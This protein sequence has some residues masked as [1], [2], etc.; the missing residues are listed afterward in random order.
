MAAMRRWHLPLLM[1][2]TACSDPE[3]VDC[4]AGTYV[5][6]SCV[7][8][9]GATSE[10]PSRLPMRLDFTDRFSCSERDR[11]SDELCAAL[12]GCDRATGR[13]RVTMA[14]ASVDALPMRDADRPDADAEPVDPCREPPSSD[15][16]VAVDLHEELGSIGG[17]CASI[18]VSDA[19]GSSSPE[20]VFLF[21]SSSGG[22]NGG[23]LGL[24]SACIEVEF[25]GTSEARCAYACARLAG[26]AECAGESGDDGDARASVTVNAFKI[27]P[28][29]GQQSST[30]TLGSGLT[31]IELP[32]MP[33]YNHV[34]LCRG[35]A[36]ASDANVEIAW[37]VRSACE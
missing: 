21:G 15:P 31:R 33:D 23:S 3:R 28:G 8:E 13:P 4:G 19:L 22:A 17:A 26:R 18:D 35:P 9:A 10:C 5:E 24:E 11:V 7:Y 16:I 14:D 36:D 1:L 27:Q 12:S 29:S 32:L 6:G 2:V 20:S 37:I 25:P 34:A 30:I